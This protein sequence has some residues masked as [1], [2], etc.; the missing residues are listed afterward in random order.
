MQLEGCTHPD[1][2]SRSEALE[3]KRMRIT[4]LCRQF[5]FSCVFVVGGRVRSRAGPAVGLEYS[6]GPVVHF[7]IL[8]FLEILQLRGPFAL[9]HQREKTVL[10]GVLIRPDLCSSSFKL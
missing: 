7:I 3:R 10:A 4:D 9:L 2:G 5:C 6:D 8:M 1:T